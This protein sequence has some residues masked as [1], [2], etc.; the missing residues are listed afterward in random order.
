MMKITIELDVDNINALADALQAFTDTTIDVG[1]V[2][3]IDNPF[4]GT[5]PVPTPVRPRVEDK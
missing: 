3:P 1:E 4:D 5:V 2:K